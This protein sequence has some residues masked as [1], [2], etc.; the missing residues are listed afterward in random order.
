MASVTVV[1]CVRK[2]HICFIFVSFC[3]PF[4]NMRL[5]RRFHACPDRLLFGGRMAAPPRKALPGP[6]SSSPHGAVEGRRSA[7]I[8]AAVPGSGNVPSRHTPLSSFFPSISSATPSSVGACCARAWLRSGLAALGLGCARAGLRSGWAAL[9]LGYCRSAWWVTASKTH[10]TVSLF[11]SGSSRCSSGVVLC[12]FQ[13]FSYWPVVVF[14]ASSAANLS[15]HSVYT[16]QRINWLP[17]L[18]D[19]AVHRCSFSFSRGSFRLPLRGPPRAVCTAVSPIFGEGNSDDLK[20]C[21]HKV[22]SAHMLACTAGNR[23]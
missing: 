9:G 6:G 20:W 13:R 3:T 12:A 22:I 10:A 1:S 8:V 23:P 4:T 11:L 16:P 21:P 18:W 17:R 15:F 7:N 5:L 14:R 2:T 19:F